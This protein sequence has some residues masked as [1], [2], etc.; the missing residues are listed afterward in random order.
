MEMH[1]TSTV[2]V[3]HDNPLWGYYMPVPLDVQKFYKEK[4]ITRFIVQIK[5]PAA[6]LYS[7]IMPGGNNTFFILMSKNVLKQYKFQ[8]NQDVEVSIKPDEST[9]GM[10]LSE[11]LAE[12]LQLDEEFASYFEKLLPGKQRNLI[13]AIGKFKSSDLRIRTAVVVA[14]HLKANNGKLDFRMLNEA[15]KSK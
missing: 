1:F 7:A 6:T 12:L 8:L 10:P 4:S 13:Y 2:L 5:K 3:F 14:D 9:Y 11:E 15:L